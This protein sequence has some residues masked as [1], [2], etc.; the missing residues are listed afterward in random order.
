MSPAE[1]CTEDLRATCLFCSGSVVLGVMGQRFDRVWYRIMG[2]VRPLDWS[3]HFV[4]TLLSS[5]SIIYVT[6]KL[7]NQ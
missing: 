3:S 1:S 6:I 2:P 4:L 5:I 7:L